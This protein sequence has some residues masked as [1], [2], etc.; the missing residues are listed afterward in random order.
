V[1]HSDFY[2]SVFGSFYLGRRGMVK[3]V[4]LPEGFSRF[5][6]EDPPPL[7]ILKIQYAK[8]EIKKE[9]FETQK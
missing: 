6:K 8:G 7:E 5:K 2:T 9:E 4:I 3:W 1:I